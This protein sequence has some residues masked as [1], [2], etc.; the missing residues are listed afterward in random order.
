MTTSRAP[1]AYEVLMAY[2]RPPAL[3]ACHGDRP[4]V[5]TAQLE[6]ARKSGT[7]SGVLK[8]PISITRLLAAP[9]AAATCAFRTFGTPAGA[10]AARADHAVRRPLTIGHHAIDV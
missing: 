1:W 10:G 2:A 4:V 9:G 3:A 5:C 7:A 6:T 8:S